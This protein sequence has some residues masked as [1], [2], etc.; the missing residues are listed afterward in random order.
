MAESNLQL[1]QE[2]KHWIRISYIDEHRIERDALLLEN[3]SIDFIKGVYCAVHDI[4]Y[5][6]RHHKCIT[7]VSSLPRNNIWGHKSNVV[8]YPGGA[9][10]FEEKYWYDLRFDN[11]HTR[12]E[13]ILSNPKKYNNQWVDEVTRKGKIYKRFFQ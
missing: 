3:V 11:E 6:F 8:V 13:K 10:I 1:D 2:S 7:I 9:T 12:R 5:E 4:R